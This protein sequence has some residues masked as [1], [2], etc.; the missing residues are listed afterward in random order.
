M[1]LIGH[2]AGRA[3]REQLQ[4][5]ESMGALLTDRAGALADIRIL[6]ATA[7]LGRDFAR[8]AE[9]MRRTSMRVLAIA[10]LSSTVLEL[11]AAL[12][13]AMMAVFCG[14]SLLGEIGFGTWGAPLSPAQA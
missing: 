3:S 6:G 13:I 11:F 5:M 14:F 10:F 1:A 4:D 12:G 7:A 8:A 9:A 2:A